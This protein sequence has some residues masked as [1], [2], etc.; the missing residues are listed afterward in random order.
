MIMQLVRRIDELLLNKSLWRLAAQRRAYV[1]RKKHDAQVAALTEGLDYRF[2]VYHRKNENELL[3]RLCDRYGSD[4]GAI[5]K[6]GHVHNKRPHT[7][8]DCYARLFNHCRLHVAKVFECGLGTNNTTVPSNMGRH[9][10]PG[11]SLRVG[12]DYFPNATVIG[13]DID[14]K[15]LFEEDRIRTYYVDQR[16]PRAIAAL[17]AAVGLTDFDLMIDDGLHTFEAGTCLF[18]NSID[19]LAPE[20]IYVVEDVGMEDLLRYRKFFEGTD[21]AVDYVNLYRPYGEL[22]DNSLVVVR[23]AQA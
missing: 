17:W 10:K 5:A 13:A 14:R 23:R 20:G 11:A 18:L 12:R 15:I 4:K 9:G 6:S 16:D 21:Y 8:T 19:K 3:S 22:K 7:Y 2:V 1:K